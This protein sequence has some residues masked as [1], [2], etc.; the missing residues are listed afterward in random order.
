MQDALNTPD[1]VI[2]GASNPKR[3]CEILQIRH[4]LPV[5]KLYAFQALQQQT[6]RFLSH[7][8]A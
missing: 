2:I 5:T 7:K 6:N 3:L 4:D 1:Y 8:L